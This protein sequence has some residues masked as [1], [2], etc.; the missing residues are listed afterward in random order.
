VDFEPFGAGI[1][2]RVLDVLEGKYAPDA[3]DDLMDDI[4]NVPGSE[5][6]GIGIALWQGSASWRASG[7]LLP[8]SG[9]PN[10]ASNLAMAAYALRHFIVART[11]DPGT[12]RFAH[13]VVARVQTGAVAGSQILTPLFLAWGGHEGGAVLGC[14]V[15]SA[16]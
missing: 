11:T 9:A 3:G 1:V 7:K 12:L 10:G 2:D 4:T 6:V 13:Q 14:L 16:L 5:S 15:G 8:L